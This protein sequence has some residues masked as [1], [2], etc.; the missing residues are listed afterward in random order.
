[1]SGLLNNILQHVQDDIGQNG[2]SKY[3][4][5]LALGITGWVMFRIFSTGVVVS[6]GTTNFLLM[7]RT[8]QC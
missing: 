6:N 1:M 7:R 4:A 3:W 8:L 2:S 5:V